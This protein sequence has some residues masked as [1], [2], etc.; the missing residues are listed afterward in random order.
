MHSARKQLSSKNPQIPKERQVILRKKRRLNARINAIKYT[1][2]DRRL[3]SKLDKLQ[4]ERG[5]LELVLKEKIKNER[6]LK[7]LSAI[8][9][10]KLNPKAFYSYTK[11]SSTYKAPVGPLKDDTATG[12]LQSNR[13]LPAPST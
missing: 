10:I 9:K 11:K 2:N 4:R 1:S 7:E 13:R 5:A 3:Q 6:V 12:T 8:G